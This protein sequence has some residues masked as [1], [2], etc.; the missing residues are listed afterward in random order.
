MVRLVAQR[1][2][3]AYRSCERPDRHTGG[4]G[5]GRPESS[6][7]GQRSQNGRTGL[8]EPG[9]AGGFGQDKGPDKPI[10]PPTDITSRTE[11][12]RPWLGGT[13]HLRDIVDYELTATFA[14][15]EAA[16]DRRETLLHNIYD[17]NR[18]TIELGKKGELGFGNKDKSFAAIV[19]VTGQHDVNEVI[20]LVDRLEMGGVE[21]SRATKGFKEDGETYAAGTYVIPFDQVFGRYAKDM[22][23]KQ[24]YPEVR[25]APN[26]P[27]EA[28]YDVS[29]WSLGCSSA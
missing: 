23:E 1:G 12:P 18:N 10:P 19:P 4:A 2:G 21:V 8:P 22:L 6:R 26:A 9:A 11:Y 3:L 14:L 29:A 5:E 28:P 13:W 7:A 20:E 16:A 15:L 17:I 24:T 27:A 25:R